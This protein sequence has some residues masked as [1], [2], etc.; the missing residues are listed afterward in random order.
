MT[1][2]LKNAKD[3]FLASAGIAERICKKNLEASHKK[4]S[5]RG[6][7]GRTSGEILERFLEKSIKIFLQELL[8]KCLRVP[9]IICITLDRISEDAQP[10]LKE[11]LEEI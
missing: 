9:L 3:C 2:F 10:F 11:F 4:N 8:N 1:F 6:I 7:P 5:T